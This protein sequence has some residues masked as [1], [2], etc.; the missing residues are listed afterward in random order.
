MALSQS[1]ASELLD[2]FHAGDGMDLIRESV[3]LVLQELIEVEAAEVI[4]AGPYERTVTRTTQAFRMFER[5]VVPWVPPGAA[6]WGSLG[7]IRRVFTQRVGCR[8]FGW[9]RPL[10]VGAGATR[11]QPE[12]HRWRD[13]SGGFGRSAS[14]AIRSAPADHRSDV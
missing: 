3:K 7:R 2:A 8:P 14:C 10:D 11:L 5:H 4:G 12:Q 6:P 9:C 1:A 13:V